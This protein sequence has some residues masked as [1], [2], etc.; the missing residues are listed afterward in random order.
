MST[1]AFLIYK[2][3]AGGLIDCFDTTLVGDSFVGRRHRFVSGVGLSSED[4]GIDEVVAEFALWVVLLEQG[5]VV[6]HL[7]VEMLDG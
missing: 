1:V 2:F 4:A 5:F 6:G 3:H 7:G